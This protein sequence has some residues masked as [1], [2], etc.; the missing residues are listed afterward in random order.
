MF[1]NTK[2]YGAEGFCLSGALSRMCH[3]EG[4]S[5]DVLRS[6][7]YSGGARVAVVYSLKQYTRIPQRNWNGIDSKKINQGLLFNM[8]KQCLSGLGE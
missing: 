1:I 4:G 3:P 5:N 6:Q 7:V 2:L 8:C